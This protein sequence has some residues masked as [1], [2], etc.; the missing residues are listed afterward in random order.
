MILGLLR[1]EP[2]DRGV[3]FV[4]SGPSGVGKST[5]LRAAMARIPGLTFSVSATTRSP[6]PGEVDGVDYHYLSAD[7]FERRVEAG[8]FLEHAHVYDRRYGTLE[9]PTDAA[10]A[11]GRSV[12][13]DI[14]VQGAASVRARRA[15]AVFLFVLP[16]SVEA[17]EAR[18]RARATE[19]AEVVARRM[20]QVHQQLRGC[21]DADYVVVND[22]LDAAHAGFQGVL[23]AELSRVRRRDRAI[24]RLFT[25]LGDLEAR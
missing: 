19:S 5:L 10:L 9:A 22:D 12:I 18:L 13:L 11:S 6:R 7:D 25:Q 4:V 2:P 21:V 1:L 20:A 23:L 16:P 8:A 15:D 24:Q 17:L 3:L 14:D